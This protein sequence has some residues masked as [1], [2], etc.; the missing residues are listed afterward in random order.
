VPPGRDVA[1]ED[2]AHVEATPCVAEPN[3]WNS[4][5]SGWRTHALGVRVLAARRQR[6]RMRPGLEPRL[7]VALLDG[8]ERVPGGHALQRADGEVRAEPSSVPAP[9]AVPTDRI[10]TGFDSEG[11][12]VRGAT[13]QPTGTSAV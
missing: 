10:S 8:D 9:S 6:E 2:D 12:S 4:S 1:L 13:C 5:R 7:A 11:V 3:Q